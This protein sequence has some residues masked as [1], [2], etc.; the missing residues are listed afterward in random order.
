M[1]PKNSGLKL[2][3]TALCLVFFAFNTNASNRPTWVKDW[4]FADRPM[5]Y[6][7]S[8]MSNIKD[9]QPFSSM[10]IPGSHDAGAMY[11][12]YPCMAKTLKFIPILGGVSTKMCKPGL[13]QTQGL[14]I[15]EQLHSGIRYLDIRLRKTPAL[16][17]QSEPY[18]TVW[19]GG[20]YQMQ[21]FTSVYTAAA[22]FVHLYPT[23][24]VVISIREEDAKKPLGWRPLRSDLY[25]EPKIVA[26]AKANVIQ[27]CKRVTAAMYKAAGCGKLIA[28]LENRAKALLADNTPRLDVSILKRMAMGAI[29]KKTCLVEGQQCSSY[30]YTGKGPYGTDI[31]PISFPSKSNKP[32]T[33]GDIRGKVVVTSATRADG[34]RFSPVFSYTEAGDYA[35]HLDSV[36]NYINNG[37]N[38]V[39]QKYLTFNSKKH[40]R[41]LELN[42]VHLPFD[43][44]RSRAYH[45]NEAFYWNL[46]ESRAKDKSRV[47]GL[48]IVAADFPGPLLIKAI[49]TYN[50]NVGQPWA[51][52]FSNNRTAQVNVKDKGRPLTYKDCRGNVLMY[53][54]C[55]RSED[56][57]LKVADRF[58]IKEQCGASATDCL[59]RSY[60]S[61]DYAQTPNP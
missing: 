40:F 31:T 30:L 9:A 42:N 16:N 14:S 59:I 57:F 47:S 11:E 12:I 5:V 27:A 55:A 18:L 32:L 4:T 35:K 43:G 39:P 50:L 20:A 24:A 52:F 51:N 58:A 6:Y 23:E 45:M 34:P 22:S 36:L 7:P 38:P 17:N 10:S 1:K 44:P 37:H 41:L 54:S 33:M 26:G 46:S 25:A 21:T 28:S 19:H 8:W 29:F 56:L 53:P 48:G 61:K 13:A 2:L 3:M 49:L 60:T 15:W